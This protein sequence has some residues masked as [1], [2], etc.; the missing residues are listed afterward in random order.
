MQYFIRNITLFFTLTS[1]LVAFSG[2]TMIPK[3]LKPSEEI[4]PS[5]PNQEVED[6]SDKNKK[7]AAEIGFKEFFK[8]QELQ[9][10]IEITL[11][12]NR[13][14]RIATLNIEAA[15][16]FYRIQKA[17]LFPTIGVGSR[18]ARQRTPP[19]SLAR[20]GGTISPSRGAFIIDTFEI[21]LAATAF[22]LDLF[23]RLRSLNKSAFEDFLSRIEA[24][25]SLKI[26]LIAQT[27][28]SYVQWISDLERLKIIDEQIKIEEKYF[29]L[30]NK[31]Y[32]K[33]SISKIDLMK[34]RNALENAKS[35]NSSF[36]RIV[37]QDKNILLLLTA[38]KD[39]KDIAVVDLDSLKLAEDLSVGLP[40]EVLLLRPDIAQAEHS[41][42]SQNANIG[43]ARAA[44][45]PSISLTG[46]YGF[47]ST[48]LSNLFLSGSKGAWNYAPQ[49]NIPIFEAGRN[50]ANLKVAEVEKNIAIENYQKAIQ[51]A[52]KEVAD[53]LSARKNL[54]KELESYQLMTKLNTEITDLHKAML[55]QGS[56]DAL[57]LIASER[58]LLIAKYNEIEV[59]RAYLTNQINLYKALGGGLVE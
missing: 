56:E 1:T 57:D 46:S 34:A 14:L 8:N 48:R 2:C 32:E 38:Q 6:F 4:A 43:A 44:F 26:S 23:G 13:D 15:Q 24:Q 30:I 42:K 33:G 36:A 7:K 37:E 53:E 39:D 59:R 55:K 20:F 27:A 29:E 17:D 25:N 9:K 45:F 16:E 18:Y 40:S 35:K 21:N 22:E 19:N 49:V 31:T 54:K 51:T 28:N 5:W 3:Y 50:L 52:F 12:N 41:L 58:D 11:K 47:S 10:I